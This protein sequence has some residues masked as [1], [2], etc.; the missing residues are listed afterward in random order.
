M[1]N[2]TLPKMLAELNTDTFGVQWVV[3]T[4]LI[5]AAIAMTTV[6]WLGAKI[7]HKNTY[8]LGLL[9]FTLASAACGQAWS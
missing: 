9:A 6:T 4:Y 3:I 1:V 5:G 8:I 2:I 7:G